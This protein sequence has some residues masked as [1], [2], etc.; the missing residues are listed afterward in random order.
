MQVTNAFDR[1][2]VNPQGLIVTT[3]FWPYP[4]FIVSDINIAKANYIKGK[5]FYRLGENTLKLKCIAKDATTCVNKAN[6]HTFQDKATLT[7]DILNVINESDR[8]RL[9]TEIQ[10]YLE[11]NYVVF[12]AP[13]QLLQPMYTQYSG[14]SPQQLPYQRIYPDP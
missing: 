9:G 7:V 11:T 5:Y 4:A 2:G 3:S 8:Q 10:K 13:V 1:I 14:I 6:Y 12:T